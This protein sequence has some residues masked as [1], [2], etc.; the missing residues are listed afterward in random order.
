MSQPQKA[1]TPS[2]VEVY[3]YESQYLR[4]DIGEELNDNNDF[5]GKC[6]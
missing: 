2:S 5:F 1:P 4:G 6:W 3:K